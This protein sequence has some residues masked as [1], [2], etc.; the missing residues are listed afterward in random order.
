MF[1]CGI[2]L[3]IHLNTL[4]RIRLRK[5]VC[6]SCREGDLKGRIRWRITGAIES[7]EAE[8]LS[9]P[10]IES[11]EQHWKVISF[12]SDFKGLIWMESNFLNYLIK[13][14]REVVIKNTCVNTATFNRLTMTGSIWSRVMKESGLTVGCPRLEGRGQIISSLLIYLAL[15]ELWT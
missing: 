15:F 8:I 1:P 7:W 9:Y 13:L 4:K 11:H 10:V 14:W 3:L 2:C 6:N 12:S 5:T